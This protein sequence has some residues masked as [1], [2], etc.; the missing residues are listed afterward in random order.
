MEHG[1]KRGGMKERGGKMNVE[2]GRGGLKEKEDEE[3]IERR[4]RKV[5]F[6]GVMVILSFIKTVFQVNQISHK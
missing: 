6:R 1:K 5:L 3:I 4:G 2:R